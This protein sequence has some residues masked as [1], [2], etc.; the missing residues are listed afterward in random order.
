MESR[1]V[2]VSGIK[3]A[4][5]AAFVAISAAEPTCESVG[6]TIEEVNSQLRPVFQDLVSSP[7]FRYY[8]LSLCAQCQHD[9]PPPMCGSPECAVCE[10]THTDLPCDSSGRCYLKND[11]NDLN[12]PQI[13]PDDCESKYALES[14]LDLETDSSFRPWREYDDKWTIDD[15]VSESKLSYVDLTRNPE[16]WTGYTSAQSSDILWKAMYDE[17]CGPVS[18]CG[19]EANFLRNLISGMHTSITTHIVSDTCLKRDGSFGECLEW[20][21]DLKGFDQRIWSYPD[22][23]SNLKFTYSLILKAL[24][25]GKSSVLR[26]EFDV[27]NGKQCKQNL[28]ELYTKLESVGSGCELLT[29]DLPLPDRE[30]T[31]RQFHN[32]STILDCLGCDKCKLWG[33]IQFRGLGTAL[34]LIYDTQKEDTVNLQRTEVIA[35]INAANK[36][37]ESIQ[38]IDELSRTLKLQ[39]CPYTAFKKHTWRTMETLLGMVDRL[40]V[41]YTSIDWKRLA[42]CHNEFWSNVYFG[43]LDYAGL[44]ASKVSDSDY[45]VCSYGDTIRAA[46]SVYLVVVLTF[47]ML[48]FWS[49]K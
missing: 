30:Q 23:I 37:S 3:I 39:S 26:C 46:I 34:K 7:F 24:A 36:L 35:L 28:Q 16:R 6:T 14:Q 31:R 11:K 38:A 41:V 20:G 49:G 12:S 25:K 22:R 27:E 44:K 33:K 15:R 32:I 4:L 48:K 42:T 13:H 45:G 18:E 43:A 1:H 5:L 19:S 21:A 8:R 29:D 9:F 40:A 17:N 10:C 2:W 47:W